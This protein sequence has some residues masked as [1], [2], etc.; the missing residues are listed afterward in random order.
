MSVTDRYGERITLYGSGPDAFW[1][2]VKRRYAG[3]DERRW[4]YL[5]ML[6]LRENAEWPL[7]L[8]GLAFGHHRG[9]VMRCLNKVR[10]TLRDEL[11]QEPNLWSEDD[12]FERDDVEVSALGA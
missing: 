11:E 9:H 12:G 3:E 1:E 2:V 8:I 7:E 4:K 10:D 6:A 5:A